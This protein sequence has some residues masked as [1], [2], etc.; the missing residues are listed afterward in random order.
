MTAGQKLLESFNQGSGP[1]AIARNVAQYFGSDEGDPS[2]KQYII[3]INEDAPELQEGLVE[4]KTDNTA[5]SLNLIPDDMFTPLTQQEINQRIQKDQQQAYQ[6][7][8]KQAKKEIG[9]EFVQQSMEDIQDHPLWTLPASLSPL[10][11]EEILT[12]QALKQGKKLA[13]PLL[14]ATKEAVDFLSTPV[15]VMQRDL[16]IMA[17]EAARIGKVKN[18]SGLTIDQTLKK[19]SKESQDLIKKMSDAEFENSVLKPDGSVMQLPSKS[20]SISDLA[21]LDKD[22][23]RID[24]K[25]YAEE[26][27]ARLD[28]LNEII[29]RNNRSGVNYQITGLN[30]YGILDFYVPQQRFFDEYLGEFIDVPSSRTSWRTEIVP[31]RWQGQVKDKA[32]SAYYMD[33]PGL[34]MSDTFEGIFA[35]QVRRG[36]GAYKSINEY[37]KALDLGR[38]K[39]GFNLQSDYSRQLWE[40]YIK[41]QKASG[42]YSNPYTVHGSMYEQGGMERQKFSK[43][44]LSFM[45]ALRDRGVEVTFSSE[46]YRDDSPDR[47]NSVNMID[48]K[49]TGRISMNNNDGTPIRGVKGVMGKDEYGNTKFMRPGGE[50]Q[51]PGNIVT[52][53]PLLQDGTGNEG[54]LELY[55]GSQNS[56]VATATPAEGTMFGGSGFGSSQGYSAPTNQ[57]YTMDPMQTGNMTASD[58]TGGDPM[59]GGSDMGVGFNMNTLMAVGSGIS[60]ISS[61]LAALGPESSTEVGSVSGMGGSRE[62]AIEGTIGG[63]LSSI[64]IVGQFY[65]IG[66]GIGKGF[67]AGANALYAEGNTAGG[68]AM[69]AM[70]GIFDP[71]SQFGRNAELWEAGYISDAQAVGGLLGGVIFGGAAGMDR[72]VREIADR[73]YKGAMTRATG[74]MHIAGTP[75]AESAGKFSKATGYPK[76]K[77]T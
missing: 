15:R 41:Q 18:Q 49:G 76:P 71:A 14:S 77:R 48:T 45:R 55:G 75:S 32:S 33:L 24:S 12:T 29:Q 6:E 68:E 74:G 28:L 66:S 13:K 53:V 65:Q 37:L 42:F 46:G 39:T 57:T 52:E 2:S 16:P 22:V 63:T 56:L 38:V 34:D 25:E 30:D 43:E 11:A 35:D 70:Q 40:N 61:S 4:S 21:M 59:T 47:N 17:E 50:Y 62:Q 69:T 19:A 36:T 54:Q 31:G 60:Q 44:D 67:E 20:E 1:Y 9:K 51:F 10:G 23:I 7:S 5:T 8:L 3:Q 73:Q 58:T 64:P 26:F 72:R 27:N